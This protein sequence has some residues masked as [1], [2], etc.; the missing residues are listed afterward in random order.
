MCIALL[1][2]PEKSKID[3]SDMPRDAEHQ[4]FIPDI[5]DFNHNK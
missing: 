4:I 3:I 2:V 1:E 5:S